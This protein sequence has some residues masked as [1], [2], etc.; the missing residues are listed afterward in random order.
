M[1]WRARRALTRFSRPSIKRTA[2][3]TGAVDVA[4]L[5]LPAGYAAPKVTV[6]PDQEQFEIVV[7][8]P[9]VTAAADLPNIQFRVTTPSGSLLQRDTA[10]PTKVAVGQ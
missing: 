7:S 5:N 4:L 2:R 8:V 9:A 1:E 3:F 6:A 10:M